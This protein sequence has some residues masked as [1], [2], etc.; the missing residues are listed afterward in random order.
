MVAREVE[1]DTL[2]LIKLLH[3][4]ETLEKERHE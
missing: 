3:C 4:A 1:L 2:S